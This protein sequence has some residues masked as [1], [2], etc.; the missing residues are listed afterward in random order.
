[1]PVRPLKSSLVALRAGT[2]L[3]CVAVA[4]L[5]ACGGGGKSGSTPPPPGGVVQG[6]G[7]FSQGSH[8]RGATVAKATG[9]ANDPVRIRMRVDSTPK[10]DTTTTYQVQCGDKTAYGKSLPGHTPVVRELRIPVGGG[11][12]AAHGLFCFVIGN[13][14]KPADAEM[15]VT[16][17]ERAAPVK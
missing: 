12:Q 7:I 11:T 17:L 13:A 5:A 15:T 8:T 9:T 6:W 3:I 4:L 1:L 2:A 16:L 10:V 14:T